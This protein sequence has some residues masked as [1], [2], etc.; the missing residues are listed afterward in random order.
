MLIN[1][2]GEIDAHTA[3]PS[4]SDKT[5]CPPTVDHNESYRSSELEIGDYINIPSSQINESLRFQILTQHFRPD[6]YFKFPEKFE[7][8][9]K[10]SPKHHWFE[11]YSFLAYSKKFDSVFCLPCA[12]FSSKSSNAKN[13][14]SKAP[15]FCKWHKV[16]EKIAEHIASGYHSDNMAKPDLFKDVRDRKIL[17]TDFFS[18]FSILL[19]KP[20]LVENQ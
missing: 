12:L 4:V 15:G 14:F 17:H 20:N 5:E 10:R 9:C 1:E 11:K 2:K 19:F 16:V 18:E 3:I 7:H 8:G 13:V 6:P